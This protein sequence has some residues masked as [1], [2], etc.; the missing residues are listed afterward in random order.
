MKF[1]NKKE[2]ISFIVMNIFGALITFIL[3]YIEFGWIGLLVSTILFLISYK[4][5]KYIGKHEGKLSISP[6]FSFGKK[7]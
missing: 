1:K 7:L 2:L 5:W 3:A 4:I 6:S